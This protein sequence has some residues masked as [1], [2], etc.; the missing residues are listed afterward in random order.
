VTTVLAE[1]S[2]VQELY[3]RYKALALATGAALVLDGDVDALTREADAL[4]ADCRAA[5]IDVCVDAALDLC[6]LLAG[7]ASALEQARESHRSLRRA[8]WTVHPCEYVPCCAEH[9][10]AER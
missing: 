6:R 5:N 1:A 2:Q 8:V 4:L 3:L 7:D 10:H 9:V